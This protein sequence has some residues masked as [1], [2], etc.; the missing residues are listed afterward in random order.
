MLP[1]RRS[2]LACFSVAAF[3]ASAAL[4]QNNRPNLDVPYVPSTEQA[5]RAMLDLAEVKKGDI[6]YDLGCGDGRIVVT[7]AKLYGVRAVGIDIDPERIAEARAN[8]KKE[9]VEHLV[10]FELKSLF[11]ADFHEATV[12]TLFLLSSVNERLRPKLLSELKP[13][14]RIVSNTFE[15]G[16][17]RPERQ[18]TV[19]GAE[20]NAFLSKNLFLW[21][22]PARGV[23]Q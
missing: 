14:T 5:V 9:G 16:D 10:R 18:T 19:E 2:L 1:T 11:D 20:E 7:A 23:K 15:M 21:K 22:V 6:V 17:W 3:A 12:V 4:A 13:G 8:A